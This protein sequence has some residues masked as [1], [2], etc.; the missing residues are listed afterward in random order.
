MIDGR[1]QRGEMRLTLPADPLRVPHLRRTVVA[2]CRGGGW[3]GRALQELGLALTE[4]CN[5]ALEHGGSADGRL[6]V[7]LDVG[8]GRIVLRI[9]G[10][11]AERVGA[12]RRALES[13][14]D[15][16][17]GESDRGRGLF[18]V[19]AYVDRVQVRTA[20]ERIVVRLVKGRARSR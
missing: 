2:F 20:G 13:C 17:E 5:N 6:R 19:R 8:P 15:L 7:L 14:G 3:R 1:T 10:G 16:P 18:L 12:L 9:V 4:V 11:R